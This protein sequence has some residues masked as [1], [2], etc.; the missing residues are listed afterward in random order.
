MSLG[1]ASQQ[2][3]PAVPAQALGTT[4]LLSMGPRPLQGAAA[5][6]SSPGPWQGAR[7]PVPVPWPRIASAGDIPPVAQRS[8][9]SQGWD[10]WA[11]PSPDQSFPGP[12]HRSPSGAASP[13]LHADVASPFPGGL[14]LC[15]PT[16]RGG[17]RGRHALG[18][19]FR[20]RC[21]A[22]PQARGKQPHVMLG[23]TGS[24]EA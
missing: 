17:A 11:G 3:G 2:P 21:S 4:P 19:T 14:S 9:L 8:L 12:R 7:L 24:S 13:L 20:D 23:L 6:T 15:N 16:R 1:I 10:T 18:G 22:L 5:S